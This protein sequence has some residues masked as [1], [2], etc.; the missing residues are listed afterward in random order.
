MQTFLTFFDTA[1][2]LRTLDRTR[3]NKQRPEAIH[4]LES[5][6]GIREGYK[7]HPALTMWRGY[8]PWLASYALMACHTYTMAYGLAPRAKGKGK[9]YDY[10][11]H[12]VRIIDE[13]DLTRSL[14]E[15]H[16]EVEV[17]ITKG[18]R[19]GETR[20]KTVR[21]PGIPRPGWRYDTDFLESHRSNLIRKEPG[22]YTLHFGDGTP[23]N[24]PY[25]WPENDPSD[26]GY[27]L[28][29][30]RADRERLRNGERVLPEH[31][32]MD[33]EDGIIL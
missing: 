25:L 21:T 5:L 10:L 19:R 20:T 2:S 11:A 13:Y 15:R 23:G 22:R 4:I 9:P 24:Y 26:D 28:R 32:T 17:P 14:G 6:L 30:S 1:K 18:K 33:E 12:V 27:I 3:H 31:L 8:E 16:D 29:V 7:H